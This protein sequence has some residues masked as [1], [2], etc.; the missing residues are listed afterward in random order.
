MLGR[1]VRLACNPGAACRIQTDDNWF[2]ARAAAVVR[3]ATKQALS[4]HK[5]R[6]GTITT[7]REGQHAAAET[8]G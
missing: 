7:A 1:I 5:T 4:G 2:A 8:Q 3:G 6:T